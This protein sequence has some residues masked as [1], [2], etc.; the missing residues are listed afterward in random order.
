LIIENTTEIPHLETKMLNVKPGGK[1][2]NHWALKSQTETLKFKQSDLM[3][4]Y[5]ASLED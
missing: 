2:S 1:Y 3:G 4:F 5:S